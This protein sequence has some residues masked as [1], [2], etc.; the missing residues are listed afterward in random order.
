VHRH[1][2]GAFQRGDGRRRQIQQLVVGEPCEVQ[3]HV[4]AQ[5]AHHPV[6]QALQRRV[7]V[8]QRRHDEVDDLQMHAGPAHLRDAAQHRRQRSPRYGPVEVVA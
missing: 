1:V 6:H 2:A 4:G 3:G 8:V 5:V 7:G